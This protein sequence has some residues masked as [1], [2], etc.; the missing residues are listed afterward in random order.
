M[1]VLTGAAKSSSWNPGTDTSNVSGIDVDAT[2]LCR[3]VPGRAPAR[4]CTNGALGTLLWPAL[5]VAHPREVAH[6]RTLAQLALQVGHVHLEGSDRVLLGSQ[7]RLR[8]AAVLLLRPHLLLQRA[9][10]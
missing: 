4:I 8:V 9:V 5:G 3:F 1:Q 2:I 10:E 7:P 6:V